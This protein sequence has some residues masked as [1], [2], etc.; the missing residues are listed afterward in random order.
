MIRDAARTTSSYYPNLIRD[1]S[2]ALQRLC[3]TVFDLL[4]LPF[5]HVVPTLINIFS[6]SLNYYLYHTTRSIGSISVKRKSLC[7]L[8][9]IFMESCIYA[10]RVK[11]ANKFCNATGQKPS[12]KWMV[13][14]KIR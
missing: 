13:S 6:S 8:N 10:T 2:E 5:F 14:S 3:F 9:I 4:L 11:Q 7:D 1:V 12:T